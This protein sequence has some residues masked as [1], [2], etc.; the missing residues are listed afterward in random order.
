[1]CGDEGGHAH[2]GGDGGGI[3]CALDLAKLKLVHLDLV[4]ITFLHYIL[5]RLDNI[6]VTKIE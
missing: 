5:R 2:D 6:M 1:M 4:L 3:L